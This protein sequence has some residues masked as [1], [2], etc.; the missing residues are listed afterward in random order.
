MPI[1]VLDYQE[2]YR[3]ITDGH[4]RYAVVEARNGHV[5]SLHGCH[6]RE[7][8][9]GDEGMAKVVGQDGWFEECAARRCFDLAVKGED[10]FRQML[11]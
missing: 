11:W 1:R 6:R 7:A 2:S 3:L 4:G 9:D 5:Y 10:H 8:P